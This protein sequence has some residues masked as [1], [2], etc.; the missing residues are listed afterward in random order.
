MSEFSFKKDFSV[1]PNPESPLFKLNKLK[2]IK[3]AVAFSHDHEDIDIEHSEF[4]F[5]C[6]N[7]CD[8]VEIRMSQETFLHN[9]MNG[10]SEDAI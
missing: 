3:K 6:Y 4:K 9:T 8:E 10:V 1:T 7:W 2:G 5:N